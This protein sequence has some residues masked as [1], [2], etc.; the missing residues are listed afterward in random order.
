MWTGWNLLVFQGEF[1]VHPLLLTPPVLWNPLDSFSEPCGGHHVSTATAGSASMQHVL[2]TSKTASDLLQ[3]HC[4]EPLKLITG[5]FSLGRNP[6]CTLLQVS[7]SQPEEL[8]QWCLDFVT[9]GHQL[10]VVHTAVWA[11][12]HL[13]WA[14]QVE[15]YLLPCPVFVYLCGCEVPPPWHLF[16]SR[17]VVKGRGAGS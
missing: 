16:L 3:E 14:I 8:I 4:T 2:H 10:R 13:A 15:S 6:L 17:S 5:N 11:S 12:C 1:K 9:C 7:R